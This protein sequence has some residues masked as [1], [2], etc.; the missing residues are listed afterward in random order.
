MKRL[1]LDYLKRN[2]WYIILFVVYFLGAYCRTRLVEG[3]MDGRSRP[4]TRNSFPFLSAIIFSSLIMIQ[5]LTR[6]RERILRTLPVS[7]RRLGI[8]LWLERVALGPVVAAFLIA[9]SLTVH[10]VLGEVSVVDLVLVPLAL[11]WGLSIAGTQILCLMRF[12]WT[13]VPLYVGLAAVG[14]SYGPPIQAPWAGLEV[15]HALTLSLGLT[16]AG[17]SFFFALRSRVVFG[18][19]QPRSVAT[20]RPEARDAE[21]VLP[22]RRVGMA[23]PWLRVF[24]ISWVVLF[25]VFILIAFFVP[26]DMA[27]G[28]LAFFGEQP[29]DVRYGIFAFLLSIIFAAISYI[30]WAFPRRAF[31][32]LPLSTSRLAFILMGFP[33]V[34]CLPLF[35]VTLTPVIVF[36]TEGALLMTMILLAGVGCGVGFRFSISPPLFMGGVVMIAGQTGVF[37]LIGT[38]TAYKIRELDLNTAPVF[39]SLFLA[40]VILMSA[41]FFLFRKGIASSSKPYRPVGLPA[42]IAS[43]RR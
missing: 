41:A 6:G 21:I 35:V 28:V 1:I 4:R 34:A 8:A 14:V 22:P 7:A 17:F 39:A 26:R 25:V 12:H 42:G 32:S 24:R 5:D 40:T 2:K 27:S 31:R 15:Q 37:F 13:L 10:I 30:F 23:M 36:Q 3:D 11:A 43:L 29:F 38:L 19:Y 18:E 20:P 33:L 16:L 9:A